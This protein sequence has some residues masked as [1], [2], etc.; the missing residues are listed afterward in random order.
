MATSFFTDI[1]SDSSNITTLKNIHRKDPQYQLWS[2]V[3]FVTIGTVATE[4]V[5]KLLL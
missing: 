3:A 4:L 5:C 1:I 2:K